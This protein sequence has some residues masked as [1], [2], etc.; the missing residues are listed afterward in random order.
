MVR[1]GGRRLWCSEW[2]GLKWTW[3]VSVICAAVPSSSQIIKNRSF[4][5]E[6]GKHKSPL[7][8]YK[9]HHQSTPDTQPGFWEVTTP[10]SD[11]ET[12]LDLVTR[13]TFGPHAWTT[14]D[15]GTSVKLPWE[16]GAIYTFTM[17]LAR[18]DQWGHDSWYGWVPYT[19]PVVLRI[20]AGWFECSRDEVIW[21]SPIIEHTDWRTY[22][23]TYI[24]TKPDMTY[25]IMEVD[26]AYPDSFYFG[27]MLIDNMTLSATF[28]EQECAF[29]MPNA[30][31]PN[32][33]GINEFF[34]PAAIECNFTSYQLSVYNRWGNLVF[35]TNDIDG[36]W[37]GTFGGQPQ[38][39]GV[40]TW[41][42]RYTAI[43]RTLTEKTTEEHVLS[44]NV[45]LL[46]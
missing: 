7:N 12:Y 40:Y 33:D 13:G 31:S 8:W 28:P 21:E 14:E 5:G 11:G 4:E 10:A 46:R 29:H 36:A 22:E 35:S 30:F 38:P 34:G 45:T 16:V 39:M 24:P 44:G 1:H 15:I 41:M 43:Q 19:N 6:P 3:L 32:N 20:W 18:S 9:C 2:S 26:W 23:F 17:D 25:L 42:I 37:D 27:N